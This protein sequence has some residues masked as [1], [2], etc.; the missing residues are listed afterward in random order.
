VYFV[1]SAVAVGSA[2]MGVPVGTPVAGCG[3]GVLA[4]G[5]AAWGCLADFFVLTEDFV[6]VLCFVAMGCSCGGWKQVRV[7]RGYRS[8]AGMSNEFAVTEVVPHL[9]TSDKM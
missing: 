1:G 7:E 3:E 8:R 6:E 2:K 4:G 5:A 9:F